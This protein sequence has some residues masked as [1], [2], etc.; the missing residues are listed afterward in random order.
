[1]EGT[2]K[3]AYILKESATDETDIENI[4]EVISLLEEK[5]NLNIKS[6]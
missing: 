1:M 3:S 2:L 4:S 6:K 5:V